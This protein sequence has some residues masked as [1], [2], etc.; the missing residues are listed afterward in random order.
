MSEY[1]L[2]DF[3]Q[4]TADRIYEIFHGGQRRVLLISK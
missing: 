3:Q 2:T 4:R 1:I